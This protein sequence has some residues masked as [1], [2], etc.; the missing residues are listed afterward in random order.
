MAPQCSQDMQRTQAS[1]SNVLEP[2]QLKLI[3]NP[4][5]GLF[6]QGASQAGMV[7]KNLEQNVG[8]LSRFRAGISVSFRG[9]KTNVFEA[10][11]FPDHIE[12]RTFNGSRS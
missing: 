8:T 6:P 4:V 9:S 5:D 10:C 1:R 11:E 2:V 12:I 7:V 3:L